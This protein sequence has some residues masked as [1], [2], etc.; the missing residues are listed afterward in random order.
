ME[1]ADFNAL[2]FFIGIVVLVVTMVGTVL[3]R[4][5]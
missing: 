5:K 2:Y 1:G 4:K 3:N